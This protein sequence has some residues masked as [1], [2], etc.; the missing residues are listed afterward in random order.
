MRCTVIC[1]IYSS[2][3][4]LLVKDMSIG[5]VVSIIGSP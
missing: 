2:G 5:I 1:L 3:W 4:L